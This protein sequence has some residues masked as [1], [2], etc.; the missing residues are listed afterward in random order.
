MNTGI[1][2]G[3]NPASRDLAVVP[4]AVDGRRVPFA[5]GVG[6]S[7]VGVRSGCAAPHMGL[8]GIVAKRR[9]AP[10]SSSAQLVCLSARCCDDSTPSFWPQTR[11]TG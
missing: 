3:E 2:F 9:S 4:A 7:W 8:E 1:F 5:T 6:P 11:R 10:Y